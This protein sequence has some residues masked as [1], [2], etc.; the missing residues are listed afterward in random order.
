M[1]LPGAEQKRSRVTIVICWPESS[2]MTI[3][4]APVGS[5]ATTQASASPAPTATISK[6]SGLTP[7]VAGSGT[8][9]G[10][11]RM[12]IAVPLARMNAPWLQRPSM[13][14]IAGE[15]M[16]AATNVLAGQS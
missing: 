13:R 12:G 11:G 5:N 9:P 14:F 7:S 6:W 8:P 3:V 15:P 4:S 1:R 16:K 10:S 2:A